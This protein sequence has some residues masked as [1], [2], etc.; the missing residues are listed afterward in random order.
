[1]LTRPWSFGR[2][3]GALALA[4]V[5]LGACDDDAPSAC[6]DG[7][8]DVEAAADDGGTERWCRAS[9]GVADGRYLRR[10]AEGRLVVE[11]GFEGGLA[12]GGWTGYG[13]DGAVLWTRTWHLGAPCGTWTAAAEGGGETTHT[14]PACGAG[15]TGPVTAPPT[16]DWGWDGVACPDGA[17]LVTDPVDVN[18]RFCEVGSKRNGPAA[19]W[20]DAALQV[21]LAVGAYADD[22]RTGTW[23]AWHEDGGL[24]EI[25][26]YSEDLRTGPWRTFAPEGW[27]EEEG[28]YAAGLRTGDWVRYYGNGQRREE[29]AYVADLRDGL[30]RSYLPSGAPDEDA[31]WAAGVRDGPY[32]R[33]HPTGGV[34]EA[35]AYAGDARDGVW[36][37]WSQ[38]G[39]K[40]SEG[41]LV[42]GAATGL[43]R[44]W[45]LDGHLASE[46]VY[47]E[48]L[49]HGPWELWSRTGGLRL[50][51]SG[52]YVWGLAQ[53]P[54][55]GIWET[56]EAFDA[57][58]Y[59]DGR[60]EGPYAAFWPN[61]QQFAEGAW[62]DGEAAYVWR[63]WYANGQLA[64]TGRYHLGVKVPD[65]W[66]YFTEDG[67]PT[68]DEV[69]F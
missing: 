42:G 63:Y 49:E 2:A 30:W 27:I 12:H 37:T 8:S 60:R 56:A 7:R 44:S 3:F 13:V 39:V 41:E 54:W 31:T 21:K 1:M 57:V 47:V 17:A 50:V 25:G 24:R 20:Y 32:Q 52:E 35:G 9:S 46:G 68:D 38:A 55:T 6:P 29:G 59:I 58:T 43:W 33:Y 16:A 65:T 51:H 64:A 40:L 66:T 5:A 4:V 22:L 26:D 15:P 34:A 10:D 62:V 11:G 23:R 61:G 67:Q 48:G 53:G 45:G 28:G 69:I 36:R 19:R 18:A 14:Y